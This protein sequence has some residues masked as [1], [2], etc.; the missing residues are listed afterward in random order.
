MHQVF[1]DYYP[2]FQC[3]AGACK[4]SCCIGWEID[5][6]ED[7]AARYAAMDGA[8][9]ARLQQQIAWDADPPHFKL[10]DGER[11]PFLN[12]DNLCDIILGKGEA[13]LCDICHLH[14]R[15]HNELPGRVESGLGLCC[16]AAGALIL[17]QTAPM[18]L[19]GTEDSCTDDAI[20]V[21]RDEVIALLQDRKYHL[22]KRVSQ[23]LQ[24]CGTDLPERSIPEW[25]ADFLELERLDPKWTE[26][27][28][29]LQADWPQADRRGFDTHMAQR[30]TEYEQFLVYLVYRHMANA[31]DP[32]E[33]AARAAFAALSYWILREAGAVQWTKTGSFTFEDQVELARL[34]SAEIEYSDENLYQ[35]LDAVY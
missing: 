3:T 1:P 6:D 7:S 16:E 11:C 32:D 31:P 9:G 25:A 27:L 34:F 14:P 4:H 19:V 15:F 12:Q 18:T 5:I 8:L 35:L 21:L 24:H 26:V 20:I 28:L 33:A 10:G 30:Q 13:G 17:G 22:P 2:K 23:M 29:S